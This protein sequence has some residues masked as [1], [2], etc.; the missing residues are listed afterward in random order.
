M[1]S[2]IRV[3][4]ITSLSGVGTISPSPT[5]VEIAG[6]TTVSTL[7]VG[8][9]LTASSDGNI[10]TTGVSTSSLLTSLGQSHLMGSVGI[11]TT[12]PGARVHIVHDN[13]TVLITD[14]NQAADNKTWRIHAGDSQKLLISA[15]NDSAAGGGR[16]FNFLRSDNDVEQFIGNNGANPWFTINNSTRRVGI[17]TT[18]PA[19]ALEVTNNTVPQLQVG[20]SNNSARSSLMHNGSHLYFDTTSGDQVFRTSSSSEKLRILSTGGVT[21]NGDTATANALDDYEEGTF[22]PTTGE[23]TFTNAEG[24]Y[25]KIG[26]Q[27]TVWIYVPTISNTTSTNNFLIQSL[28]FS[29]K[30]GMTQAVG[31]VMIRYINSTSLN[32]VNFSTYQDAGWSYLRIYASRDDANN[33]EPLKHSDF[34]QVSPGLR[35]CHTYQAA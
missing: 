16:Y 7:K 17:G 4:K 13:P 1:A 24:K 26:N 35:I 25:T 28:P 8:T 19:K 18:I 6:I 20:M 10:F 34:T 31:S 22:T 33:Y 29:G 21:F 15:L 11:G 9:G 2:E 32:G 14:K 3:D 30:T 12:N 27:V 5:G 23:G